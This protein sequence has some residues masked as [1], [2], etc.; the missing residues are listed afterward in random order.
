MKSDI[1]IVMKLNYFF[2]YYVMQFIIAIYI[3]HILDRLALTFK[4]HLVMDIKK[5]IK[6]NKIP[7]IYA[8]GKTYLCYKLTILKIVN[9]SSMHDII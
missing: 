8:V 9:I 2:L 3:L 5:I 6:L 7:K 4:S 1:L